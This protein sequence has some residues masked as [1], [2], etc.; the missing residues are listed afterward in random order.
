MVWLRAVLGVALAATA[1]WL[2]SV[3]MVQVGDRVTWLIG[4]IL[5]AL[6]VLLWLRGRI[7]ARLRP[8]VLAGLA[9]LVVVGL[10]LPSVM[11]PQAAAPVETTGKWQRFDR[12]AIATLVR[13]GKVV[14]VDVTADWCITCKANKRLVLAREPVAS[15]LDGRK[16]VPM[17]ADWTR[18]NETIARYLAEYGRYGIPFNVVYGPNAPDGIALPELLTTSAVLAAIAKARGVAEAKR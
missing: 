12:A 14:F 9:V 1:V 2:L 4:A 10:A 7:G 13:S 17:V 11:P 15:M 8:A 18:P 16:V 6:V 5:V 3:L